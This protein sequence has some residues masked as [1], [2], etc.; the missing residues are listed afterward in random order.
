[1]KKHRKGPYSASTY[2]RHFLSKYEKC[3]LPRPIVN[4][5]EGPQY[6]N[7]HYTIEVYTPFN[8]LKEQ[9]L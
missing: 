5:P 9:Y 4:L 3:H 6:S 8:R 7:R 2:L 1:M